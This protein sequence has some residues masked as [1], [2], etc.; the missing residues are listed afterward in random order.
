MFFFQ[1][2]SRKTDIA[3]AV[4]FLNRVLTRSAI[5]FMISD[6]FDGDFSRPLTVAAKR[7]DMI[8]LPIFDPVE[9]SFPDV[10]VITLQD[11]ETG[12]QLELNT[13]AH[14]FRTAYQREVEQQKKKLFHLFGAH[15]IDAIALRTDEDYL[16][17]LR[18]FFAHREKKR[19]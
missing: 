2:K 19:R 8:A 18:S 12:E 14:A 15:H 6:F 17:L 11:P 4:E 5:V 9:E 3:Q 7:H 1:P 16:P 10:G 13:S